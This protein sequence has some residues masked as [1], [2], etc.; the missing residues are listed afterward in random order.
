MGALFSRSEILAGAEIRFGA[1]L[2]HMSSDRTV[3]RSLCGPFSN[4]PFC[5]FASASADESTMLPE[6]KDVAHA[7][8][9]GRAVPAPSRT[10]RRPLPADSDDAA[11]ALAFALKSG[12]PKSRDDANAWTRKWSRKV[13]PATNLA[14]QSAHPERAAPFGVER[15]GKLGF[16]ASHLQTPRFVDSSL[17]VSARRR[18]YL[19]HHTGWSGKQPTIALMKT[20]LISAASLIFISGTAL[21]REFVVSP[22]VTSHGAGALAEHRAAQLEGSASEGGVPGMTKYITITRGDGCSAT[23]KSVNCEE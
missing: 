8:T 12:R 5:D 16:A 4:I 20:M 9:M 18:K 1:D 7:S 3:R 19:A 11:A 2:S 10:I 21:A 23:R 13:S 15:R 6:R 17:T 22:T 14:P